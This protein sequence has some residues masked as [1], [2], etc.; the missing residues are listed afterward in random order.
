[1]ASVDSNGSSAVAGEVDQD[2]SPAVKGTTV[3]VPT[4]HTIIVGGGVLEVKEPTPK[5]TATAKA[6]SPT[7][8]F[9]A[10]P[11]STAYAGNAAG[12]SSAVAESAPATT[13]HALIVDAAIDHFGIEGNAV[14][15]ANV[16]AKAH[17]QSTAAAGNAAGASSAVAESAPATGVHDEAQL[18]QLV[19]QFGRDKVA[20]LLAA[21]LK[22]L[23]SKGPGSSS[24]NP[25]TP[26]PAR[27]T[28]RSAVDDSTAK[29]PPP[30]PGGPASGLAARQPPPPPG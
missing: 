18:A 8:V 2:G 10:H 9:E 23:G 12:A 19:A 26:M 29:P 20:T 17:P 7:Q 6:T 14:L 5:T 21:T 30:P 15:A 22:G 4:S 25:A 27:P 16:A 3:A 28:P 13:G 11:P 1:M 24:A